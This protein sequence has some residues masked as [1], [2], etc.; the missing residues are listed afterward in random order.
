VRQRVDLGSGPGQGVTRREAT[1]CSGREAGVGGGTT[2][3]TTAT[4]LTQPW[5]GNGTA[6]RG[7]EG[8]RDTLKS[9]MLV[10]VVLRLPYQSSILVI[11]RRMP[12]TKYRSVL[13]T[14]RFDS[15]W[16]HHLKQDQTPTAR[17]LKTECKDS[18]GLRTAP[19]AR[20]CKGR[21]SYARPDAFNAL[22]SRLAKRPISATYFHAPRGVH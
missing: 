8:G 13:E 18:N 14:V 16:T 10:Q 7:G 4:R 6:P 21:F 19:V 20:H 2:T 1:G 15:H 3:P 11:S 17:S 22:R 5:D 9:F 12:D